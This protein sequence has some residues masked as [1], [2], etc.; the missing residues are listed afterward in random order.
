[1]WQDDNDD[2]DANMLA[3]AQAS[4]TSWNKEIKI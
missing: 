3:A 1:M 2:N 4:R